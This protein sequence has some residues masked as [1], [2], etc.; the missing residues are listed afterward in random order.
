MTTT[1]PTAA[2][3]LLSGALRQF[4]QIWPNWRLPVPRRRNGEVAE[5]YAQLRRALDELEAVPGIGRRKSSGIVYVGIRLTD[6][7]AARIRY[8]Q[9]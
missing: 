9:L 6:H 7:E 5:V 8:A 1:E 2:A 3:C 4:G